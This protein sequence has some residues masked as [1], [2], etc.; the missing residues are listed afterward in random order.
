MFLRFPAVAIVILGLA[1]LSPAPPPLAAQV[2]VEGIEIDANGVVTLDFAVANGQQ[3]SQKQLEASAQQV[4]SDDVNRHSPLRKVSLV[5]LEAACRRSLAE[6][7]ELTPEMLFL[8][9]VQRLDYVFVYPDTNDLVIAGPAEGF[10][11]DA[12]GR[13]V[14]TS[15]R[16]PPF[17]LDDLVVALQTIERTGTMG[18]SID[19]VAERLAA[20]SRYVAANNDPVLP[21]QAVRRF[22]EMTQVLGMHDVRV[23][24]VPAE[25]HF[26][27]LFV[28][29]DYRMKL[30]ALDLEDP[31]IRGFR[32]QL[33]LLRAQGNAY[34]RFWFIPLYEPFQTTE[35]RLA[36]QFSGQR[37][38]LLSQEE[39]T[40]HKGE[41]T[42]AASTRVSTQQFAKGF[43]DR[44]PE[45]AEAVP[46][47]AELQNLFDLAV[48]AAL[49]KKER[50]DERVNW[51][52][53]LFLDPEGIPVPTGPPPKQVAAVFNYKKARRGIM[54]ALL[55]GG[56]LI[57]PSQ[58]V[59]NTEFQVNPAARLDGIRDLAVSGAGG[60]EAWWWD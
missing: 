32:S 15:T 37:A 1:T 41:R 49:I 40:D 5:R 44:F 30:M 53:S 45:I 50:L 31:R 17:R 29:A 52:K 33:E 4:L 51:E 34:Q 42:P 9:G 55:G 27:Q 22:R 20:L 6:G 47:F 21:D 14:G 24:G 43:T 18:C 26:G 10:A 23:L 38:Q 46:V 28:E 54:I 2:V 48:L 12:D 7:K 60:G 36:F 59:E 58:V 25:A 19:P 56:V 16:R 57:H 13:F 35:D 39:Y 8:A 3:L 11:A